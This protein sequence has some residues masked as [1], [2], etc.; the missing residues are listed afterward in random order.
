MNRAIDRMIDCIPHYT[1]V[2]YLFL[3]HLSA[4]TICGV[5]YFHNFMYQKN[6]GYIGYILEYVLLQTSDLPHDINRKAY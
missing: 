4:K 6:V 2:Q 3:V 5:V 1:C